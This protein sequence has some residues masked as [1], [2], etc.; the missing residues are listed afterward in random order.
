MEM[1]V[2]ESEV[3]SKVLKDLAKSTQANYKVTLKQ[4]LQFVNCK[5]GLSQEISIDELVMEGKEDV[6]R[7]QDRI[8]LFLKWLQNK[9]IEGYRSRGERMRESSAHQRAYGFLRGFFVNAGMHAL[10]ENR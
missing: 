8:N 9:K 1:R 6:T 7:T 3:V 2:D 4:F 5:E 10:T